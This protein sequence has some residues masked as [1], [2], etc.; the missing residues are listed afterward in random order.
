MQLLELI[1]NQRWFFIHT[2]TTFIAVQQIENA[3]RRRRRKQFAFVSFALLLLSFIY[4]EK[5]YVE[6]KPNR[7]NLN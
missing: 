5:K 4:A 3:R 6:K 7:L 2:L 1:D